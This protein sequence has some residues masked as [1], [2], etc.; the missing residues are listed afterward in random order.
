MVKVYCTLKCRKSIYGHS[1]F[2]LHSVISFA[3]PVWISRECSQKSSL[4]LGAE[5]I[6]ISTEVRPSPVHQLAPPDRYVIDDFA[7]SA[8]RGRI[9]QRVQ[10]DNVADAPQR[11]LFRAH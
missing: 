9:R 11:W 10:W 4:F 3:T 8:V 5:P 6:T 2:D 7:S 1:P